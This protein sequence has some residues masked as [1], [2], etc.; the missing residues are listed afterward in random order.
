[1]RGFSV[2]T[3]AA[4]LIV[5]SLS[6]GEAAV[7]PNTPEVSSTVEVTGDTVVLR[8]DNSLP[9]PLENITVCE[10]SDLPVTVLSVV[11]DGAPASAVWT[12]TSQG[13]VYSGQQSYRRVIESFDSNVEF[14]YLLAS[15]AASNLHWYAAYPSAMFGLFESCCR[16]RGDVNHSGGD[17]PVDISDLT[18]MVDY[19]FDYGDAPFCFEE[20]NIDGI[21][22]GETVDIS[23][24]TYLI[25][26]FYGGGPLP[27]P[28]R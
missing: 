16:N 6:W 3:S 18:F 22:D 2:L 27:P 23:D 19:L 25:N 10:F 9:L 24:L 13:D 17:A 15:G 28:C 21:S 11:I 1:M 4:A 14:R 8:I 20:A 7:F 26:Y 12:E 5:L